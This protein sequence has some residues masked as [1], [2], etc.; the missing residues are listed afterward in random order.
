[1]RGLERL[2]VWGALLMVCCAAFAT[3]AG[4]AGYDEWRCGGRGYVIREGQC[5]GFGDGYTYRKFEPGSV[6]P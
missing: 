6:A 2:L 5:Q 1:M 4:C 3:I